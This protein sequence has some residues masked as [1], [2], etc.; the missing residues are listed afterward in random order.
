MALEAFPWWWQNERGDETGSPPISV[1]RVSA[2]LCGGAQ[3]RREIHLGAPA[4]Q[5]CWGKKHRG[6]TASGGGAA[7]LPSGPAPP[8]HT[9]QPQQRT[10]K[11]RFSHVKL[12]ATAPGYRLSAPL[13]VAIS[14]SLILVAWRAPRQAQSTEPRGQGPRRGRQKRTQVPCP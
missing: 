13:T 6:R 3:V 9:A 4:Y 14:P 5:L 1:S 2:T 11:P 12:V 10:V 8:H 7:T